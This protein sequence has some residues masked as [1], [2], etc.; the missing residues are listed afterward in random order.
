MSNEHTPGGQRAIFLGR[1]RNLFLKKVFS[2]RGTD[3]EF[4]FAS[5]PQMLELADF[6]D[7]SWR[8]LL[9]GIWLAMMM[10]FGQTCGFL[11]AHFRVMD[12]GCCKDS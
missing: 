11:L 5:Q 9:I 10:L 7:R 4:G 3:A 1:L 12:L 2:V 8:I 6:F